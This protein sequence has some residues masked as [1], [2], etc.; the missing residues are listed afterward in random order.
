MKVTSKPTVRFS[1]KAWQQMWALT[2]ECKIEISAMGITATE[3]EK[4]AAGVTEDYYVLEYFVYNQDCTGITTTIPAEAIHEMTRMLSER[5]VNGHN[6]NV[7]WHSHVDMGTG[8]SP[9]DEKQIE[10]FACEPALISV[11]TNKK[12]E[13]NLR[14]DLFDPIRYSFME[15]PHSVDQISVLPDG[16]AK[17]MVEEH[18]NHVVQKAERLSVTKAPSTRSYWNGHGHYGGYTRVSGSNIAGWDDEAWSSGVHGAYEADTSSVE[19]VIEPLDFPEG[20]EVLQK[21]YDENEIGAN[22][23]MEL[24]AQFYAKELSED[25]VVQELELVHGFVHEE[26]KDEEVDNL[27]VFSDDGEEEEEEEVKKD[28]TND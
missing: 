22:D 27:L 19:E 20:L 23:A 14:V 8:Q 6:H 15:C 10:A 2:A 21:A 1:Q 26:E 9:I 28:G 7:W 3:A 16:W 17:E 25:E 13:M 11:I 24:F 12:G 4:E 18:V 5:G